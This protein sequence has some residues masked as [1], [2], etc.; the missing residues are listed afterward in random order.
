VK[1]TYRSKPSSSKTFLNINRLHDKKGG[2]KTM[3]DLGIYKTFSAQS[4]RCHFDS[5]N[6][7]AIA[8]GP[9]PALEIAFQVSAKDEQQAAGKLFD[10]IGRGVFTPPEGEE[11]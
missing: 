7:T 8:R 5:D 2:I 11:I 4:Y 1:F 9:L 6:Q 10:T 3:K